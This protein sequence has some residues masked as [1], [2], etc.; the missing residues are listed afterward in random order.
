MVTHAAHIDSRYY[1]DLLGTSARKILRTSAMPSGSSASEEAGGAG[2]E[3]ADAGHDEVDIKQVW[4]VKLKGR[5]TWFPDTSEE[6]GVT[7]MR[8]SKLDP[9]LC[10]L[11]YGKGMNRHSSRQ[12]LDL[13]TQWWSEVQKLSSLILISAPLHHPNPFCVLGSSL[14]T[15]SMNCA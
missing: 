2:D 13:N 11:T 7:Y 1:F 10:R 4:C 14:G 8:L 15:M 5:G 6:G 3:A 9:G 12:K